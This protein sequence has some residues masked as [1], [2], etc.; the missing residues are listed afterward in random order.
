MQCR[1]VYLLDHLGVAHAK[2]KDLQMI[3]WVNLV[4]VD[5]IAMY[6]IRQAVQVV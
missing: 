6:A 3:V 1:G 5:V 2:I 4:S